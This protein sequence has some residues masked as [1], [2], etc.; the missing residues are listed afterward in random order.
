MG[1]TMFLIGALYVG[2]MALLIASGVS[3]GFVIVIAVVI[4]FCQ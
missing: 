3:A 1:V 2:V 4:L